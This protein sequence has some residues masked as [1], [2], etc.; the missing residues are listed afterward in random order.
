MFKTMSHQFRMAS[1]L[2][3]AGVPHCRRLAGEPR[4]RR[5]AEPGQ[6]LL[7]HRWLL[8]LIGVQRPGQIHC[9]PEKIAPRSKAKIPIARDLCLRTPR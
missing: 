7:R 5:T 9:R 3:R 2:A 6:G 4:H 1:V 8:G